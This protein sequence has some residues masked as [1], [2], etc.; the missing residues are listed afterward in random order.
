[1]KHRG[2]ARK[3][4]TKLILITLVLVLIL[5]VGAALVAGSVLKLA[6]SIIVILWLLFT[7]F[8]ISFFRDPS[9]NVPSETNAIVSPAH[10]TVDLIDET[11]EPEVMGGPCQR[12]SI[13][14]SVFNVHVQNA[15]VTGSV[16]Y[17]KHTTGKFLSATRSDC[18]AHN[19]NVLFGLDPTD[20]PGQKIG[21]RLIAGLIARRIIPWV[22]MGDTVARGERISLI[23][24]GSRC[25]VYLP[26]TVKIHVKL[27]AKVKGGETIIAS[28]E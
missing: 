7:I 15:P 28:F 1:M 17:F 10:G 24:Y 2:K 3:A 16:T 11:Q 4:G 5:A 13:F 14:L 18:G 6:I 26:R 20:Y 22:Q 27:G 8:A 25:D 23:Q 12:I 21:L 19:E 9:P